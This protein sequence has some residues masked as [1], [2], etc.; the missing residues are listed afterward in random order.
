MQR[1]GPER[2]TQRHTWRAHVVLSVERMSSPRSQTIP[3]VAPP[4]PASH[5]APLARNRLLDAL[6]RGATW[7]AR[8]RQ[9]WLADALSTALTAPGDC[10]A[11]CSDDEWL[12]ALAELR[13]RLDDLVGRRE[14]FVH[15]LVYRRVV[16]RTRGDWRIATPEVRDAA[17]ALVALLARDVLRNRARYDDELTACAACGRPPPWAFPSSGLNSTGAPT[18]TPPVKS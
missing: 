18:S 5:H 4:P 7:S 8:T 14:G 17:T 16:V 3:G 6:D 15:G 11:P 13:R 10:V 2:G 1:S 12:R 9:A